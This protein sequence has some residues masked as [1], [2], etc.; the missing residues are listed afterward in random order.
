MGAHLARHQLADL[1]LDTRYYNAHT[2]ASDALWAGL[3]LVTCPHSTFAGRVATSLLHA[4]GLPELATNSMQDYE[5]FALKLAAN[6]DMLR[7]IKSKLMENRNTSPLFDTRRY[8]RHIEAAYLRM[9][10]HAQKGESAAK[11]LGRADF[12][13]QLIRTKKAHRNNNGKSRS[14]A[15]PALP[16]GFPLF[17]SASSATRAPRAVRRRFRPPTFPRRS[18]GDDRQPS[19]CPAQRQG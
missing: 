18:R 17:S 2:T 11:F 16:P 4:I 3:P 14:I 15:A 8:T 9:W 19:G 10:E 1:F 6:P 5:Q 7:A 12:A 13:R